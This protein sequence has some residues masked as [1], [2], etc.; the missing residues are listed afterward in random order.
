MSTSHVNKSPRPAMESREVGIEVCR[1]SF[2]KPLQT[3][4]EHFR[5]GAREL[6]TKE[7][8]TWILTCPI[9]GSKL[10][11]D[12]FVTQ[13]VKEQ[14]RTAKDL[15]LHAETTEIE[16]NEDIKLFVME[17]TVICKWVAFLLTSKR[18]NVEVVQFHPGFCLL[19]HRPIR[20]TPFSGT[21]TFH[22]QTESRALKYS[23]WL[24]E[25]RPLMLDYPD[26]LRTTFERCNFSVLA[27]IEG[28]EVLQFYVFDKPVPTK[29]SM[30]YVLSNLMTDKAKAEVFSRITE[31]SVCSR[32]IFVESKNRNNY[33]I[34]GVFRKSED[35]L[36]LLNPFDFDP[37]F[38]VTANANDIGVSSIIHEDDTMIV[39]ELMVNPTT[40]KRRLIFKGSEHYLQSEVT[41]INGKPDFSH[42]D[43]EV[44]EIFV[45]RLEKVV[46]S[47]GRPLNVCILGGGCGILTN[48]LKLSCPHESYTSVEISPEVTRLAKDLFFFTE[49]ET[50][51]IVVQPAQEF[52]ASPEATK[53]DI[54]LIDI[55]SKD[56]SSPPS[57]FLDREVVRQMIDPV[58]KNLPPGIGFV[59]F[60][61]DWPETAELQKKLENDYGIGK[62]SVERCEGLKNYVLFLS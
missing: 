31:K 56:T 35:L 16:D 17:K 36:K 23:D 25:V 30:V 37:K 10:K 47:A 60:N 33:S 13:T 62:T 8:V 50:T 42:V 55:D 43:F 14:I 19:V 54:F 57:S 11:D 22:T 6:M 21:I 44:Y 48:Y 15:K 61:A 53:Y 18:V 2:E 32:I 28:S 38:E 9:F 40:T 20:L 45:R 24:N 51:S 39:E 5:E 26:F 12:N 52:L 34:N 41:I 59:A 29:H 7:L 3:V 49:S 4:L 1:F 58:R 27:T 46:K